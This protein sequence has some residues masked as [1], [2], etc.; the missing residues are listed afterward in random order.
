MGLPIQYALTYPQRVKGLSKHL[1]LE[2]LGQ[3]TFESPNMETFRALSLAYHVARAGGTAPAVFSAAN[4][5]A[6]APFCPARL[7]FRG[8][9]S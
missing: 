1:R 4:E 8:Y 7:R 6:V 3:L 5:A 9:W 2:K